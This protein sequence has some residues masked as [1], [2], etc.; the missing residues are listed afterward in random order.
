[1]EEEDAGTTAKPPQTT[2]LFPVFLQPSSSNN[3]SSVTGW[4]QNSSFTADATAINSAVPSHY[5]HSQL[6]ES[7]SEEEDKAE[8]DKERGAGPQYELVNSSASDRG[9]YSDDETEERRKKKKKK[10]RRRELSGTTPSFPD[11]SIASR[12]PDVR[13]WASSSTSTTNT[14]EYYFDSRGDRDNLAFGSLYRYLQH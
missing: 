2:S 8:K 14:K 1:M 4:L 12:K 5:Q 13:T 9:S 7:S 3:D 11:Y 6:E 10:R